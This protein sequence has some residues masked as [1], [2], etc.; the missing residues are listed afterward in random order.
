MVRAR[1]RNTRHRRRLHRERGQ[2][3]GLETVDVGLP[4]CA[5]HHLGFD[6]EGVQEV[7]DPLRRFVRIE[8]AAQHRV[9]GCHPH[10]AP[11]GVAVVA[12]ARLDPDLGFVVRFRNVLIAV[13]RH[14][15]GV[16]DRDCIRSE[17]ERLRDVPAV[18][19]AAR[20]H[21]GDL[22]PLAEVVD[23]PAGLAD[24]R[25]ARNAGLLRREVG[26]GAGAALHAVDVDGV[27]IALDRHA[28]V[29]VHAR[30]PQL[31]LDGDLPVRRLADLDDLQG[32]VVGTEPI[33]VAG[34]R[35][36]ID[37]GGKA[38]HL[39]HLVGHLLPHE[40]PAEPHLASLP[41]EELARI[42]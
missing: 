25:H 6:G 4:A 27:R 8:A 42:G 26:A 19:D 37:A 34:R 10:R 14:Q 24:R 2:V 9:L 38:P 33:R 7:V 16:S 32:E 11:A 5:R 3:F 29:V 17:G 31:E 41:D 12:M 13:E 36:L 15:D 39:R 21:E 40:M 35:T 20:I 28:H 23:G 30:R 1:K 22:A 18:A